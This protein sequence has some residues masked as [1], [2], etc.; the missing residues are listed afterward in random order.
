MKEF[1]EGIVWM[2]MAIGMVIAYILLIVTI[3]GVCFLLFTPP[4]WVVLGIIIA[5]LLGAF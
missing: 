1:L 5:K 4:G 3:L 2:L